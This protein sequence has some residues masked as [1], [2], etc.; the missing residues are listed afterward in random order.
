MCSFAVQ[1]EKCRSVR[2]RVEND[3]IKQYYDVSIVYM[4]V[5]TH[6]YKIGCFLWFPLF[7]FMIEEHVNTDWKV[8]MLF[9]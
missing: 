5:Y 1:C 6:T 7:L 8:L 2:E 4:Y 3:Y 9:T